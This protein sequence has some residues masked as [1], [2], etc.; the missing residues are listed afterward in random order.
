MAK[1]GILCYPVRGRLYPL[2][3]IGSKLQS[4]GHEVMLVAYED[5]PMASLISASGLD[6]V[7]IKRFEVNSDTLPKNILLRLYKIMLDVLYKFRRIF[8]IRKL[9]RMLGRFAL[10]LYTYS[11]VYEKYYEGMLEFDIGNLCETIKPCSFNLLLV[12]DT[13]YAAKTVAEFLQIPMLSFSTGIPHFKRPIVPPEFTSLKGFDT[14]LLRLRNRFLNKIKDQVHKPLLNQVNAYRKTLSLPPHACLADTVSD[15]HY[16][17]Q[18]PFEL[19]FSVANPD[20]RV[21]YLGPT[22]D[23]NTREKVSFPWERLNGMPLIYVSAGTVADS[24]IYFRR[25]AEAVIDLPIQMVFTRGGSQYP[26]DDSLPG[27]PLI[28]DYAPQLE[29]V[30]EAKI[31]ITHGSLNT[32][33]ESLSFGVPLICIPQALDQFGTAARVAKVGAGITLTPLI[34][35]ASSIRHAVINI[36]SDPSYSNVAKRF[37]AGHK[38]SDSLQKIAEIVEAT[39]HDQES[40]TNA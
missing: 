19:E 30:S 2:I 1:I 9:S 33:N 35:S 24:D 4:I 10:G 12:S 38:N 13:S 15:L 23:K 11:N 16:I 8:R 3:A 18:M 5:I 6:V 27:D 29:L 21:H 31:I 34:V 14:R 36:I 40:V 7:Y 17:L 26:L 20:K 37:Q 39:I 25:I 32:I 28:V 22:Y